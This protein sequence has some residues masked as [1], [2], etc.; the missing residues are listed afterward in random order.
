MGK[1]IFYEDK[2]FSGRHFECNYDCTDLMCLLKHCNSIRVESGCFMIY[3]QSN[4]SGNQ[5]CL[6]RGEYPDC[7]HWMGVRDCVCSCRLI[8]M[9][10]SFSM[11]LYQ[12]T[13]FGG[14]VMDLADDCPSVEERFHRNDIFSCNVSKGNWL[15]YEHPDFRGR[16]YLIRPGEYKRFSEWGGRNA[17]VGSIRRILEY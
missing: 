13:E 7:H 11:R 14:Q 10:G 2:N 8:P 15:F 1:I 12:R 9:P 6:R 17:R 3:D 16:M 5:Y 4:Y